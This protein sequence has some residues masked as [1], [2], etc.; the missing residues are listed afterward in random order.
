MLPAV[1][2]TDGQTTKKKTFADLVFHHWLET[3]WLQY[4]MLQQAMS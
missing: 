1:G 3:S 2:K 4:E